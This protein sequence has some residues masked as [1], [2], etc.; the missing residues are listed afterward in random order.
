MLLW[1]SQAA[2]MFDECKNTASQTRHIHTFS[3]HRVQ[4]QSINAP[5]VKSRWSNG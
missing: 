2:V 5:G 3:T 4:E 1:V